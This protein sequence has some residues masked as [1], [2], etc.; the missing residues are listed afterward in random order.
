MIELVDTHCHIQSIGA[1]GGEEATR[2]KWQK[3][4]WTADEVFKRAKRSG[5]TKMLCVGCDLD[6]SRLA[7]DFCKTYDGCFPTAGLHPHEAKHYASQPKR[8]A[9][10][11]E[12]AK[13]K[14]VAIGECGLDYFYLHS[15]K[16]DQLEVLKFQMGLA[17]A[18]N[19]P[20]I[21]HIRQAFEDFWPVFD[22]YP[23]L[24]G[25]LHSYTDNLANMEAALKRGLFIG[26]NGIATFTK[27]DAQKEVYKA[28]PLN[29][30]LLETDSPFL[31]PAPYRGNI[32]EPMRV[33]TVAEFLASQR[34]EQ[35]QNLAET[36][37][38]NANK[39]FGI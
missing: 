8:L 33:G 22:S 36:T 9:E 21:F 25:V 39:L 18:H 7:I 15:P 31:T 27:E 20:L 24:R 14:I 35:L 37:S 17:Q 26:V 32:N 19:L 38:A 2:Q 3:A 1:N 10:F 4:G 28:I 29:A 12:L 23:S 5:V 16:A 11:A 6:D 34:S 30:L 13:Q